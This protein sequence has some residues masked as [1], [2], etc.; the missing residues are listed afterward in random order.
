MCEL[1]LGVF[2]VSLSYWVHRHYSCFINLVYSLMGYSLC[3]TSVQC[4]KE[5]Q[6]IIPKE[7]NVSL[8]RCSDPRD[9]MFTVSENK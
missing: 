7:K 6:V 3:H 8:I 9:F 5:A 4:Q 1:V 2:S